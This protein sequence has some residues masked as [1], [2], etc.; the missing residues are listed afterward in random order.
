LAFLFVEIPLIQ[1]QIL[2]FGHPTYAFTV[3]VLTILLFSSLGSAL[4]RSPWLRTRTRFGLVM[5][6]LATL[7]CVTALVTTDLD[8]AVMGWPLL[9]RTL[10]VSA[11]LAPAAFLMGL[12]FPAG[13]AWLEDMAPELVPWAW[14]VN[15]CSSVVAAVLAAI[16]ALSFGFTA[17][18]LLG[19]G[20]YATAGVL[21]DREL[22]RSLP[23]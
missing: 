22:R 7:I 10:V 4:A 8:R 15:G 1:R 23:K 11:M 14:A 12:P 21:M 18:L 9:P 16:L 17:V 13:L 20:A 5:G 2:L 3:V 6:L 19:A